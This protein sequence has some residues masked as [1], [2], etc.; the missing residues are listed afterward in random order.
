MTPDDPIEDLLLRERAA[1]RHADFAALR[2]LTDEKERLIERLA[3]RP[4]TDP[5]ALARLRA[6]AEQNAELMR[7]VQRGVDSAVATLRR[8]RQPA[9][10]L[11]TYDRSG[12]TSRIGAT[13]GSLT[14]RA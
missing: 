5:V 8:A 13:Q 11:S 14:R 2:A 10:P 1:L 9:E 4:R 7:A 12:Q 3:D 6:M